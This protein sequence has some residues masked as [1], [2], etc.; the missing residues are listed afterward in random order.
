MVN[1]PKNVTGIDC[2]ARCKWLEDWMLMSKV[3]TLILIFAPLLGVSQIKHFGTPQIYNYPKSVYS[4]ATQNWG[5]SQ[6]KNGFLYFANNNGVLRFDG[7]NWELT[8]ISETSPIRSVFVDDQD[9]IFVGLLSDFGMLVKTE[10]GT[11]AFQSFRQ[12]LPNDVTYFGDIWKIYQTPMGIVFQSFEYIFIYKD[13]K[14][15][16]KKP[17]RRFNYSFFAND[18]LFVQEPGIGLFELTEGELYKVEWADD[19][20]DF[21]IWSIIETEDSNLVIGTSRHGLYKYENGKLTKWETS[22]N[23]MIEQYKLFS[24]TKILDNYIAFGTILNGVFISDFEGNIIQHINRDKGLQNNTILSIFSD[25]DK[26]LWLGLDNG[27]DYIEINS[28]ISFISNSYSLGSGYCCR[29][30]ED[31]LYLGTN[32]GVFVKSFGKHADCRED[33]RLIKNTEGQVWSLD[34]FNGQLICGHNNGT[35][36]IE[37]EK[38]TKISDEEGCWKYITLKNNPDL[39]LGGHYNGLSLL[40]K[41]NGGYKFLRKIKG[42]NL[43]SQFLFQDEVGD[44][45]MSNASIGVLRLTLNESLDSVVNYKIYGKND[46]LPSD[47]QNILFEYNDD[48]YISTTNGIYAYNDSTDLFSYDT[49]LNQLLELKGRLKTLEPDNNGNLWFI[50]EKESGVLRR[51]EDLSYTKITSPLEQLQGRYIKGYEFIYPYNDNNIFIGLDDGF[52]HYTTQ[53]PKSYSEEFQSYITRVEI[54]NIDSVVFV[55]APK[56]DEK[57]KFP[58]RRNAFRFHYTAPFYENLEAL[59]FSFLLENYS[60]NWSGWSADRYKDFTNLREGDYVFKLKAK[61]IYGIES[62]ISTFRFT[63]MPPWYR[64]QVAFYIYFMLFIALISLSVWFAI[65]RIELSKRKEK[66]KHE[67]E[68]RKKEEQY[69]RQALVAEKE[70]IRLRNEKLQSEMIHRDKELAN[71]TMSVIQKNEVLIKLRDEIQ[72]VVSITE[73]DELKKKLVQLNRRL[74]REIDNKKQNK[75]FETYF[76]EV[77]EDFFKRLTE[78]FP[79]LTPREQRLCAYIRMNIS[80][81]E[82]A[83]LQNISTRGIEISRYRLRKK[84]ELDRETNLGTF[85]SGI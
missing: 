4:A 64:S 66:N 17:V 57:F 56:R 41:G 40:K 50:A 48:D 25:K 16:F 20:K 53:M 59:R 6:D 2:P 43:S 52:A 27:I 63:V 28:P 24:A 34:I 32:Q 5:V 67:Q 84:L 60:E 65:Y 49:S 44:I 33:F 83:A 1:H 39:L 8:K 47:K 36:I 62:G 42:V 46:G 73:D 30:F 82:I 26:D 37:G 15:E 75:I 81:K 29:V 55:G 51:N 10:Q 72:R 69:K 3:I 18:R 76:D 23:E 12:L 22:V 68:I 31:K 35:F 38:A 78:R 80:T 79:S 45:W 74:V 71:Q 19:L 54:P 58:F 77:H 21:E 14:I 11:M 13:N 61:N 9:R 85:I 70:I 7:S